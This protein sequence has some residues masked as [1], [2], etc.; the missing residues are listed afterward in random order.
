MRNSSFCFVTRKSRMIFLLL[1]SKLINERNI[2][3][4]RTL[5]QTPSKTLKMEFTLNDFGKI[6]KRV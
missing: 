1:I 6:S 3:A 5:S 4:I 2:A